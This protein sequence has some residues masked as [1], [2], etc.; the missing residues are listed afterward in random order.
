MGGIP[1]ETGCVKRDKKRRGKISLNEI[2]KKQKIKSV[3][4]EIRKKKVDEQT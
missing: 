1:G 4:K 2:N 3:R